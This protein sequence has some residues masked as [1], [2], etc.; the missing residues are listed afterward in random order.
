MSDLITTDIDN[1]WRA[2]EATDRLP[3]L[4]RVKIFQAAYYDVASRGMRDFIDL[5]LGDVDR[6][7]KI[8]IQRQALI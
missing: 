7:W 4:D 1:F 6:R 2:F 5:R 8:E 3:R